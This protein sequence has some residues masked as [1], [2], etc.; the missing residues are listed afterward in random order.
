MAACSRAGVRCGDG[1]LEPLEAG[2]TPCRNGRCANS[3]RRGFLFES[4]CLDTRGIS[5]EDF[6]HKGRGL[7][8]DSRVQ[9][10]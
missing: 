2:C 8:T 1:Q 10:G 9:R 6:E 5:N 4:K 7:A 3:D